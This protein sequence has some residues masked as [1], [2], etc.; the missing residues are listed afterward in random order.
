MRRISIR[1]HPTSRVGATTKAENRFEG[2][3]GKEDQDAIAVYLVR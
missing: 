2:F 1:L 3:F